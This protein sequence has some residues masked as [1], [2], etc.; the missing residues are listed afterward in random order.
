MTFHSFKNRVLAIAVALMAISFTYAQD[1]QMK[2]LIGQSL[3]KIQQSSPESILNCIA[4]LKR[5]DAM[6]P[7]SIQPKYMLALQ[8][9]N[10]AVTNPHAEA[11]ENLLLTSGMRHPKYFL[12]SN[13]G[14][15]DCCSSVKNRVLVSFC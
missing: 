8:S 9:L 15:M 3:S 6:F 5:I 11:T 13:N 2:S 7:D 14:L 10:Y 4:E 1:V 12:R